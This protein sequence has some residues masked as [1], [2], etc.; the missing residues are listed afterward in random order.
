MVWDAQRPQAL[1]HPIPFT[2]YEIPV[3]ARRTHANEFKKVQDTHI[4]L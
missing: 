3:A 2:L 1:M 4:S